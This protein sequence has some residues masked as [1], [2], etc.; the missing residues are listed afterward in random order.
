MEEVEDV[1]QL[2]QELKVEGF[3]EQE[4]QEDVG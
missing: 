2:Q 4:D 1:R 3:V